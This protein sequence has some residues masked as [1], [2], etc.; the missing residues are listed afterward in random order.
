[1]ERRLRMI[2]ICWKYKKAVRSTCRLI[3]PLLS[4]DL[5]EFH[6]CQTEDIA[7]FANLRERP[8]GDRLIDG[9]DHQRRLVGM[10]RIVETRA[11]IA[12]A[13]IHMMDIYPCF[14][15]NGADAPDHAG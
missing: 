5:L 6:Q 3:S 10:L 14:A 11:A 15:Q 12:G 8:I 1:M 2:G 13:D 4:I 7:C 9:D